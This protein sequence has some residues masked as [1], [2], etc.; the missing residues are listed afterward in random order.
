M[1]EVGATVIP[2]P[3]TRWRGVALPQLPHVVVDVLPGDL[4]GEVLVIRNAAVLATLDGPPAVG[5]ARVYRHQ[6]DV[7]E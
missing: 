5:G 6:V 1:T 4:V 7:V 3:G 2:R